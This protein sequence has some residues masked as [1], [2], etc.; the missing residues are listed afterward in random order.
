[1][2]TDNNNDR[3]LPERMHRSASVVTIVM[4]KKS[5]RRSL[6]QKKYDG[7]GFSIVTI[8]NECKTKLVNNAHREQQRS[9]LA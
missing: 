9:A 6:L 1:M 7:I 4:G 8:G 3:R 2:H 5:R